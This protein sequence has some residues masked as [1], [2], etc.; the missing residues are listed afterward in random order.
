M[1][2]KSFHRDLGALHIGCEKPHSYFIPYHSK[3]AADI[4]D[5]AQSEWFVGLCGEW[6]FRYYSSLADVEDVTADVSDTFRWDTIKVPL[7]WQMMLDRDYDKPHYTNHNYPFPVD[8]PHIPD[9]IPCG[10]YRR[11]F[12]V[13]GNTLKQKSIRM[14]FEGVDSCFYLYINKMF[15]GYSQ[16]SH[17]TSEFIIDKYLVEGSNEVRVLVLKWCHGSYLEDQDKYRMSGI[18]REVYLLCRDK[19]C[20][21]DIYIKQSTA[22]DLRSAVITSEIETNGASVLSYELYSPHGELLA[23]GQ[24]DVR[25][26]VSLDF[27]VC[28]PMLWS[29]ETPYL[30]E[31]YISMGEEHIRQQIGIRRFEIKDRI[32]YINGKKV[33]C[34]GVNRHDTH[35]E[36]GYA[37]PLEH[38]LRDLYIIKANNM[39]MVR[40]SH[41]P[42]DPRFLELCDRLGIYVC[43]ETDLET[44]GMNDYGDWSLLT[45]SPQWSHAYLDR[46]ERMFE[47][48]KNHACVLMWSLG[49][50]SGDGINHKLMADYLHSRM[51]GCIVH[52]DGVTRTRFFSYMEAKTAEERKKVDCEF[53]DVETRMYLSPK[54]CIRYYLRNRNIKK[55]FMLCEY[56]H[57]MGNSQGDLEAYWQTI[58]KYDN[59]FG[60]CVWE[61]TDHSVNIGTAEAPKYTYGGDFGYIPNDGNFCV[62]GLL[63]PDRRPHSGMLEYK[64]VLRPVRVVNSD[65]TSGKVTL[66]NYRY[67]TDLSDMDMVWSVERN[68]KVI[69]SGR[70]EHLKIRPQYKRTYCLPIKDAEQLD[71]YCYLNLCF[72]SN[73]K[74][75]WA[76]EGYEIC[77]EQLE[78]PTRYGEKSSVC[79]NGKIGVD[80]GERSITVTDGNEKYVIDRVSGLLTSVEKDG[81]RLICSPVEPTIWRAPTDNDRYVKQKW[82]LY[83]YD[84]MRTSCYSCAVVVRE[85][86][87]VCVRSELSL[88]AVAKRPIIR[89][90]L[91]YKFRYGEGVLLDSAVSML[92]DA[93]FIP[94]LGYRFHMPHGY[95][96]MSYFGRG[97]YESYIDKR[98]ASR[99][100]RYCTAVTEHFEPYIRPQENMAHTDTVWLSVNNDSGNG[101][102]MLG[103]EQTPDFSFNCSHFTAEQL[104]GTS[105]HHLLTP[106]E[107]TV[108]HIDYKQS[109]IGSNSCGPKLDDALRLR[110]KNVS[111]CFRILPL[112]NKV[113]PFDLQL[114][115]K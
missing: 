92:E 1:F 70:I 33:K 17:S 78:L 8:P 13:D 86:N 90:T 102:T 32:I 93:Y 37:V 62:D 82:M 85:E 99:M 97:P 106:I 19:I 18:F 109:G 9:H 49:N 3:N 16:V 5:R 31:L 88:G 72:V 24:T 43:N 46:V 98:H 40:T 60:A 48:A 58:Y 15:V 71:G 73:L 63:Y 61:L 54:D 56:A 81:E 74:R 42:N 57:A 110:E 20:I 64:Q 112:N 94:R 84:R 104:T 36:L 26:T 11:T 89:I 111:F 6:D 28:A 75:E 108:V 107:D 30:Y 77:F 105:H 21:T 83:G 47:P 4:G 115:K 34:K 79:E 25:D 69:Q 44:H 51:N 41:Y 23:D 14:V 95:E 53:V 27:N 38:M 10:L 52:S 100:G 101:L 45:D 91:T 50:E 113:D 2:D 103:G 65:L 39:N 55:P 87:K 68:G 35:P 59:F 12:N 22:E 76:D 29:D 7:N 96:K 67:F 114:L 66:R 80:D